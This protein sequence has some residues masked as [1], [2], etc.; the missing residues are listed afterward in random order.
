MPGLG[1]QF[2]CSLKL[3]R[4]QGPYRFKAGSREWGLGH[5]PL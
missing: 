4:G 3:N 1:D 2:L 5:L